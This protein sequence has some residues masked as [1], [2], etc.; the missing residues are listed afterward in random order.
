MIKNILIDIDI[1][2]VITIISSTIALV[3]ITLLIIMMVQNTGQYALA[4]ELVNINGNIEKLN[5]LVT[6]VMDQY[7]L[8]PAK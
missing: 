1:L 5:G 8:F 6:I 4:T 7:G 3:A 2:I